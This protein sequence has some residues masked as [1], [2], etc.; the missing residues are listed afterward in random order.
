MMNKMT[1]SGGIL[2]G[3]RLL[4][5]S[6]SSI[7]PSVDHT[8]RAFYIIAFYTFQNLRWSRYL[9]SLHNSLR[10]LRAIWQRL[11]S[12]LQSICRPYSKNVY[13]MQD[14]KARQK[15]A[16]ECTSRS[17][18]STHSIPWVHVMSRVSLPCAV[19]AAIS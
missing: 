12:A 17:S 1:S 19:L 5:S 13:M 7:I 15:G 2:C 3:S 6:T 16:A 9:H 11:S 10:N 14:T 18:L 4:V 8:H